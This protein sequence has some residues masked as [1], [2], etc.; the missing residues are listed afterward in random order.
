M[1]PSHA[2]TPP[3]ASSAE[4][5]RPRMYPTPMYSGVMSALI[6]RRGEHLA[7]HVRDPRRRLRDDPNHLLQEGVDE[8]EP[9]PAYAVFANS[10]PFSPGDEHLRARRPLGVRER[11]VLPHDERAPERDHHQSAEDAAEEAR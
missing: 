8:R 2:M 11:A 5:F 6:G 1:S 7:L 9:R 10:P 4:F 3:A